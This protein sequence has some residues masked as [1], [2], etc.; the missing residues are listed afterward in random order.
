MAHQPTAAKRG[1]EITRN[2]GLPKGVLGK[3]GVV[4]S[5]AKAGRVWAVVEAEDGAVFRSDDYGETWIRL[6][7]A[8]ATADA[9]LVLHAY[10]RRH[11]RRGYGLCSELQYLASPSTAGRPSTKLPTP[12]GDEHALW[13]D[14]HDNNRMIEGNDGGACVSFNGGMTWS[15]ILNQPTAQFYHVTTDNQFPYRVYGSQQDNTAICI[16]SAN[17][18]CRNP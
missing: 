11:A 14:P 1:T 9:P 12:H 5:P 3:I 17:N 2:P 18:R 13:I 16:P 7:E 15:S 8:I 6:S 10:H 4:A